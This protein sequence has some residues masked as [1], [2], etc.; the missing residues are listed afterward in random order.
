MIQHEESD[1]PESWRP[2]VHTVPDP[3][4]IPELPN[5]DTATDAEL[6]A[7]YG[8]YGFFETF[9]KVRLS[10]C[11]SIVRAQHTA[12]GG[13]KPAEDQIDEEARQHELYVALLVKGLGGRIAYER[14]ALKRGLGS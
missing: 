14:E 9:R 3:V 11:R 12:N 1:L 10:T 13:K 8:N 4:P 2:P 6:F 7:W 5:P